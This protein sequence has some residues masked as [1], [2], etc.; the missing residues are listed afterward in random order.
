MANYIV[1][2]EIAYTTT[3]SN[4]IASFNNVWYLL[5]NDQS[6]IRTEGRFVGVDK[7]L[8][9][10]IDILYLTHRLS[11]VLDLCDTL[12]NRFIIFLHNQIISSWHIQC[13]YE[14]GTKAC[15]RWSTESSLDDDSEEESSA[16]T[17]LSTLSNGFIHRNEFDSWQYP[18]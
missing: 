2:D 12:S 9:G 17:T 18:L 13:S 10:W 8:Q 4:W 6:I 3:R 14:L 1:V 15:R 16:T 5:L 11:D 7:F